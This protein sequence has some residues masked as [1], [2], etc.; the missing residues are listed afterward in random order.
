MKVMV[1]ETLRFLPGKMTEGSKLL[2]ESLAHTKEIV[3][4]FPPM[5]KY[6]PWL[7]GG[8][9]VNTIIIEVEY[10]SLSQMEEFFE[11]IFD[12]SKMM[13]RNRKWENI[14]ESSNEELYMV[15]S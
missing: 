5:R 4:S 11:K 15:I 14:L 9:S 7:G 10:D 6:T 3:G 1:R 13:E 12:D 2:D 8:S